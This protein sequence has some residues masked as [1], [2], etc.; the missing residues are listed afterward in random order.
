MEL[1]ED[2]QG[3][4]NLLNGAELRRWK[5][6]ARGAELVDV[7][8]IAAEKRGPR[9][10]RQ[11]LRVDRIE[12]ARLDR[13]Y[14]SDGKSGLS[15]HFPI[16]LEIQL[17]EKCQDLNTRW[18]SYFK[19]R[20][21]EM[22]SEEV[23]E[24]LKETWAAHP[25]SIVDPRV[26]WEV[27]WNKIKKVLQQVWRETRVKE[28]QSSKP[29]R[30]LEVMRSRIAHGNTSEN[31]KLLAGLEYAV[32]QQEIKDAVTWRLRSK[33]RISEEADED[34]EA[35]DAALR[36]GLVLI[37]K[38]LNLQQCALLEKIPDME[39]IDRIVDLLPPEKSPG[40]DGVTSD[41]G[42][43]IAPMLFTLS[44]QPLME[45]LREAQV[46][47]QLH[48]LE[49][50]NGRQVLDALF[51]DDTCLLL[52]ADEENWEKATSIIQKFELMS[53]ARLNVTKSLVIPVGFSEPTDW[54]L[55][56]KSRILMTRHILMAI[57][58]YTLMTLGLTSDGYD[59]LTKICRR[60]I[61]G[62][63]IEEKDKKVMIAWKKLCA[64]R[65]GGGLGL[66]GFDT[67]AKAVKMRIIAKILNRADLDWV[68]LFQAIVEWKILDTQSRE[69]K[70][71]LS[72]ETVLL[73]GQKIDLRSSP[74]AAL[75]LQGWWEVRKF[76]Q[77]QPDAPFPKNLELSLVYKSIPELRRC[78]E[79]AIRE[80]LKSQRKAGI[81]CIGDI[82]TL[83]LTRLELLEINGGDLRS[84]HPVPVERD[85][86]VTL[87]GGCGSWGHDVK[88]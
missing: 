58:I 19:F 50:G 82:S 63:N 7:F 53:G 49:T 20:I 83:T 23:K 78:S 61:W 86:P 14:F 22:Q 77:L 33:A 28:Q 73:I 11:W 72:A 51:T 54:L 85:Q 62:S 68:F 37:Q 56:W 39:E 40:L 10:T 34:S 55:S 27:A 16:R 57:L 87:L 41:A 45:M 48:G 36:E 64:K 24:K 80:N 25:K 30:D 13:V 21:Q 29:S 76:L 52:H 79:L 59:E 5:D 46:R 69:C 1:P 67:Q 81:I 71:G 70:I 65:D 66:M 32:K 88:T 75:L 74:T 43:P 9:F 12:F 18:Q 42:C 15:D 6:L 17:E 60:F 3:T 2:T 47:G 4:A 8:F 26:R 38:R 84:G 44:T 35:K 31:R